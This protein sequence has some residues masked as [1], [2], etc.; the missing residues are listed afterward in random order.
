MK[1]YFVILINVTSRCSGDTFDA[2][3][4]YFNMYP[5]EEQIMKEIVSLEKEGYTVH[6]AKVE[7]RHINVYI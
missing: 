4:D 6:Y 2:R 5:T 3:S 7:K 1:Q